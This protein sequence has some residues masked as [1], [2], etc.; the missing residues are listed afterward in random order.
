M[1]K[2][3]YAITLIICLDELSSIS[4]SSNVSTFF[5]AVLFLFSFS[6]FEFLL[7]D[8]AFLHLYHQ[9]SLKINQILEKLHLEFKK[10][11]LIDG[12]STLKSISESGIED[13]SVFTDHLH[14]NDKGHYALSVLF[15]ESILKV[16]NL[17]QELLDETVAPYLPIS[18][19]DQTYADIQIAKLTSEFPF[20]KNMSVSSSNYLFNQKAKKIMSK[21]LPGSLSALTY[22]KHLLVI[23]QLSMATSYELKSNDTLSY[24]KHAWSLANWQLFNK[25]YFL[26]FN[27]LARLYYFEI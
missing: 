21:S 10:S 2:I 4:I 27:T 3:N 8:G 9:T 19:F 11:Y 7:G 13:N 15:F 16:L 5:S 25:K 24:V 26:V 12:K 23:E 6:L 18:S 1:F 22:L 14:P 17:Q 20:E